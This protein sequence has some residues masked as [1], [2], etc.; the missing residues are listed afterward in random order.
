MTPPG[1]RRLRL[2]LSSGWPPMGFGYGLRRF[3]LVS[4]REVGHPATA[5][6]RLFRGLAILASLPEPASRTVAWPPLRRQSSDARPKSAFH[7]DQTVLEI[8]AEQLRFDVFQ[9]KRGKPACQGRIY[10]RGVR[11]NP[12]QKRSVER[13]GVDLRLRAKQHGSQL[14]ENSLGQRFRVLLGIFVARVFTQFDGRISRS[15]A[16]VHTCRIIVPS[17]THRSTLRSLRLPTP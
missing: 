2:R 14:P 5:R 11:E 6:L 12:E 17:T 13:L 7:G 16:V 3:R 15:I 4:E 10:Y 9:N 8:P 1:G